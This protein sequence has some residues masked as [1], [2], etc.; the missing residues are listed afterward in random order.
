MGLGLAKVSILGKKTILPD[1]LHLNTLFELSGIRSGM[2]F[3][4]KEHFV[5]GL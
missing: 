5:Y 2:L 1:D 4:A 3:P